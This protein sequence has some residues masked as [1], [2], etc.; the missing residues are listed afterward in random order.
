MSGRRRLVCGGSLLQNCLELLP[1]LAGALGLVGFSK[2]SSQGLQ[3]VGVV[4]ARLHSCL[5]NADGL[6][7]VAATGKRDREHVAEARIVGCKLVGLSEAGDAGGG[8]VG[9]DLPKAQGVVSGGGLGIAGQRR[10][11]GAP[12]GELVACLPREVGEVQL[13]FGQA[14]L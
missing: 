8:L 11:N 7:A 3:A 13:R 14:R 6:G 10:A 9:A 2:V 5:E 12:G 4:R 1:S